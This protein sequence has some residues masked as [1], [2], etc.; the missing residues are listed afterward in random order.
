MDYRNGCRDYDDCFMGVAQPG[1][2][3]APLPPSLSSVERMP[4][5]VDSLDPDVLVRWTI[6]SWLEGTDPMLD[7]VAKV[8]AQQ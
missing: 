8:V 1:R 2:P 6:D 5:L 4:I 7:A 3:T